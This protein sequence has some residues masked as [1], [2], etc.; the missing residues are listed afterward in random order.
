MSHDESEGIM[1]AADAVQIMTAMEEPD[2]RLVQQ[3]YRLAMRHVAV[4]IST[5]KRRYDCVFDIPMVRA[6][7]GLFDVSAVRQ[8]LI[9]RLRENG[10][11][12]LPL[13]KLNRIYINWCPPEVC[14][15]WLEEHQKK[16]PPQQHR[17]T[18]PPPPLHP[19]DPEA[20]GLR[21]NRPRPFTRDSQE[22]ML[23]EMQLRR[24]GLF[25]PA[26]GGSAGGSDRRGKQAGSR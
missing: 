14:R 12:A 2:R 11:R 19:H 9:A 26:P 13:A 3:L 17:T 25:K 4:T 24:A 8:T 7:Y 16:Q 21:F 18:R 6:D 10:F 22:R 20:R 23:R 15:K 5:E 1:T